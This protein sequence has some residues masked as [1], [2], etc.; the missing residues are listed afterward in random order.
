M[1]ILKFFSGFFGYL[2]RGNIYSYGPQGGSYG[3]GAPMRSA[4]FASPSTSYPS[5][6]YNQQTI[7]QYLAILDMLTEVY[8]FS[9]SGVATRYIADVIL[10]SIRD[11]LSVTINSKSENFNKKVSEYIIGYFNEVNMRDIIKRV[12]PDIVYYGSFSF[13]INDRQELV[14]LYDPHC[15]ITIRSNN[16]RPVG[17]LINGVNGMRIMPIEHARMFTIGHDDLYLYSSFA[18]IQD[19]YLDELLEYLNKP[20]SRLGAFSKIRDKLLKEE[21]EDLFRKY[22]FT[23]PTPLFYY[24]RMQLREYIVKQVVLAL[25]TLRDLLFPLVYTLQYEYPAVSF[26]VENLADRIEDILNEYVDISGFM[27]VKGNLA[28]ILNMITYSIRV[29]P[30]FRGSIAN[31]QPIDTDTISRKLD[32]Y[33]GDLEELL[34]RIIDDIGVP[35]NEKSTYWETAKQNERA[36]TKINSITTAIDASLTNLARWLIKQKYPNAKDYQIYISLFDLSYG[37]LVRMQNAVSNINEYLSS[38]LDT[39]RNTID[40]ITSEDLAMYLNNQNIGEFLKSNLRHIFYNV[41]E[42]IDWETVNMKMEG[43]KKAGVKSLKEELEEMDES[44]GDEDFDNEFSYGISGTPEEVE[45]QES[46]SA[47]EETETEV[48]EAEGGAETATEETGTEGGAAESES[49]ESETNE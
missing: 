37:K 16:Y 46:S 42:M 30:D 23:A 17:Y 6:L 15:I 49:T 19:E 25:T 31:L 27:G 1:S 36:A 34:Q 38:S 39:I 22:V 13:Y 24:T 9:I 7:E 18:Q 4:R 35:F 14:S 40:A 21:K 3:L 28:Q 8:M 33:K 5:L 48:A 26:T 2:F 11:D 43:M 20:Q 45:E 12:L 32:K 41:N 47:V 10:E 44:E 29:L